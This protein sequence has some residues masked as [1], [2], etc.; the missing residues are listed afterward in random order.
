MVA[1]EVNDLH[2]LLLPVVAPRCVLIL[3]VHEGVLRARAVHGEEVT[4]GGGGGPRVMQLNAPQKVAVVSVRGGGVVEGAASKGGGCGATARL[5]GVHTAVVAAM[6]AMLLVGAAAGHSARAHILGI[7]AAKYLTIP[8]VIIITAVVVVA[9]VEGAAV[10][11]LGRD[12]DLRP[13]PPRRRQLVHHLTNDG[14]EVG[15]VTGDADLQGALTCIVSAAASTTT[16]SATTAG[17]LR[18][19]HV[20]LVLV[21]D[22]LSDGGG[23]G[24]GDT[25]AARRAAASPILKVANAAAGVRPAAPSPPASRARGGRALRRNDIPRAPSQAGGASAA[26][27]HGDAAQ[28]AGAGVADGG[29]GAGVGRGGR[30]GKGGFWGG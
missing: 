10:P 4:H 26:G 27:R 13:V 1:I 29:G 9:S 18:L 21:R 20:H 30:R 12:V 3:P 6:A 5:V 8:V 17:R 28:A 24:A 7:I 16:T 23:G 25:P 22:E 19:R 15:G 2:L 11:N 14:G